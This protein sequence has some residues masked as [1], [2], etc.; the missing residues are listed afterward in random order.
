M[1][2]HAS[3]ATAWPTHSPP[4]AYMLAAATGWQC[5]ARTS[6][7]HVLSIRL[8]D[9]LARLRPRRGAR[10]RGDEPRTRVWHVL[11]LFLTLSLCRVQRA[12]WRS[13]ALWASPP[14]SPGPCGRASPR[15]APC[16]WR[17]GSR[18]RRGSC[19]RPGHRRGPSTCSSARR[20]CVGGLGLRLGSSTSGTLRSDAPQEECTGCGAEEHVGSLGTYICMRAMWQRPAV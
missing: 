11:E 20:R 10:A 12:P 17:S 15:R 4:G 18:T 8:R 6:W 16:F 19:R 13:S 3:S 1:G 7:W 9:L 2:A 14:R 5:S